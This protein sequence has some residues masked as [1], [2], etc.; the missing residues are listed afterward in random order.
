MTKRIATLTALVAL[1]GPALGQT[2]NVENVRSLAAL[3][4]ARSAARDEGTLEGCEAR[5]RTLEARSQIKP[6]DRRALRALCRAAAQADSLQADFAL[7][8]GG[9]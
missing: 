9:R 5:L 8:E 6:S 1:A 2:V 4:P 3:Q 7:R